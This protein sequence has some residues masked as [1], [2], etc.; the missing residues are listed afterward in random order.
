ME[1]QIPVA[2]DL[3]IYR[4][5]DLLNLSIYLDIF[6][7]HANTKKVGNSYGLYVT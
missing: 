1:R 6:S 4:V 2:A 3:K 5:L 7:V